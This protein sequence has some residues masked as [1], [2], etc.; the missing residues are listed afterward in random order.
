M[1]DSEG[2]TAATLRS[3]GV[4][5]IVPLESSEEI[6]SSLE[7]FLKQIRQGSATVADEN[8][9]RGLARESRAVELAALFDQIVTEQDRKR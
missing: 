4:G 5:T 6:A 8:V 9:V 2:D 7:I 1:V 3:A